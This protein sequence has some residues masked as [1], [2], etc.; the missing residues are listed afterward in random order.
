VLLSITLALAAQE[1]MNNDGI[2]RLLKSG[3]SEDLIINVINQQP[4][5]YSLGADDLIALKSAGVSERLITAMLARGKGE[6]PANAPAG[7]AKPMAT[8]GAR[9]SVTGPGLYYKKGSEYFELL[10]EDV[11][12]KTSGAMKSIAS[13]GIV[14]KNLN[15]SL[16]G[17]SSRNFLNHPVEVVLS[18]PTGLT[19]NSYILLPMKPGKGSREF[20]VGPVNQKSGVAKGAIAFGVEKVGDNVFRLVLAT[21]LPPGEYGILAATP[22]EPNGT[23]KMYTFRV[24][25]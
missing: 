13:A 15:G 9:T 11:G 24:L 5:S 4:G 6:T 19:V 8:T 25:L 23:S 14:K 10:T 12:W 2:I 22:Q 16:A 20:S 1:A 3:M 7:I 17:A 21:P 18:P